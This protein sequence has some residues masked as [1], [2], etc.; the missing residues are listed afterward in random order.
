MLKDLQ[1]LVN[2]MNRTNSVLDKKIVLKNY[3]QCQELLSY[4][5]SPFTQFN[6]TSKNL[7]KRQDLCEGSYADMITLLD[8]LNNRVIT[9]HAALSAVN[10]FVRDNSDYTDLIYNIID[11]NLKIRVD[12][13]VINK[14][15]SGCIPTFD[16]ALANKY[17]DQEAKID[18]ARDKWFAS[19]KLDG[20]RCLAI[21]T[22]D[23][24]KLYSR[25]GKEFLTLNNVIEDINKLADYSNYIFDGEVCIVDKKGNED[26]QS[27]VKEIRRKDHTIASPKFKIFD[28]IE[29][30]HFDRGESPKGFDFAHRRE[31]L[32]TLSDDINHL[33]F[34]TLDVVD[35]ILIKSKDHLTE[36]MVEAV[37][38]GWEGLIIRKDAP[39]KGKRSNDLLKVK[40]MHDA[41]YMVVDA[42]MGPFRVIIDG[43]E[44]TEEMLSAVMIEHKGNTVRV[45][46]GFSIE[47]RR[48]YYQDPSLI[49]GHIMT[50]QYFEES[51]DQNGKYSLRFPVVK[52]VYPEGKTF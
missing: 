20:V 39:Y 7:K 5:Y 36:M 24:Y 21:P 10:A 40:K 12:A 17:E 19:R 2:D 13:K 1:A 29:K 28:L 41:E 49:V 31:L 15:F 18:F 50:V 47:D 34:S 22:P 6:V 3:P 25:Q 38:E 51:K 23:G 26:F 4:V 46:S 44:V 32:D 37:K 35:Q 52:H 8:D 42:E 43:K 14:V 30:E 16:V 11:K 45:G 9:G 48:K 33:S 27:I